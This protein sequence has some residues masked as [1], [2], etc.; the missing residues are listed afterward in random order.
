MY[1]YHMLTKSDWK[2]ANEN[3]IYHPE[4]L[5]R[6]GFI[7]F[8]KTDQIK[9][10]ANSFYKGTKDMILLRVPEK[11]VEE[12]LKIEPPLEAPNSGVLFPHLYRELKPSEVDKIIEFPCDENGEFELPR[13]MLD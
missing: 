4:S 6:E 12:D 11:S 10:V 9:K 3:G 2:K 8:S 5:D 13:E 7:H 1:I